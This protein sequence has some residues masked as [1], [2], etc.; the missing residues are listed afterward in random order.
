MES[1]ITAKLAT[2]SSEGIKTQ[3]F[4]SLSYWV[5]NPGSTGLMA[6]LGL[7]LFAGA[8]LVIPVVVLWLCARSKALTPPQ[9]KLFTKVGWYLVSFGLVGATL[10]LFRIF[11]IVWVSA[12]AWWVVWIVALGLTIYRLLKFYTQELPA[13]D[14]QY[15]AYLVKK[16][17]LPSKKKR[18]T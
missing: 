17:Y 12:R 9:K 1:S 18:K 15:Q 8:F 3:Q 4:L 6:V 10:V 11:G 14:L 13:Q 7:I 16:R 5:S 2:F